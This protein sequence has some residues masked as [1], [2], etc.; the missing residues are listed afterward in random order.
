MRP[1][2]EAWREARAEAE[3]VV[4]VNEWQPTGEVGA[5]LV[6]ALSA[7][8]HELS[9]PSSSQKQVLA[10]IVS[11]AVQTVP[12]AEH[13]GVLLLGAHGVITSHAPSN[14]FVRRMDEL[15]SACREGP[16]VTTL[17]DQ[18]T[19]LVHDL[20]AETRRWPNFARTAVTC[21]VASMLCFQLFASDATVGALNLYSSRAGA[22]DDESQA[23]GE[24]FAA[25]AALALGRARQ[26]EQLHQA[27]ATRDVIGQAKGILME[28]F[29][30][31]AAAAFVM[32][33]QSSQQTN[34]RVADVAR[35]LATEPRDATGDGTTT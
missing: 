12:G 2:R 11:G 35:W 32:L 27:L 34:M 30:I 3:R 33:V 5:R 9:T 16:C 14:D 4:G 17:R 8:A 28:R 15:Q 29:G 10:L 23:L 22:F 19:V 26:M 20:A 25:H 31:D 18:H 7:A 6:K 24:L 21:G 1:T 13:A